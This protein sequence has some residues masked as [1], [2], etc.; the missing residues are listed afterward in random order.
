MKRAAWSAMAI[1]CLAVAAY[2]LFVY[3]V[4][5]FAANV[6]HPG[7]RAHF[8][9]MALPLRVHIFASVFALALGSLQFAP[10][11][12]KAWPRL[13][14]VAGRLYLGVGVGLGGL[15][16]LYMALNA[17]GGPLARAGFALLALAWL[18]TGL[19]AYRAIRRGQVAE[20]RQWMVRNW[21]LT[22]AA[23][24]LR[25]YLPAAVAAGI[26]FT[27][28]FAAIAWLCWVPNLALAQYLLARERAPRVQAAPVR[29]ATG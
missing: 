6:R 3:G 12:R 21:S 10:R 28:A 15:S 16:G 23:V 26:D 8:I 2:A 25:F 19:E 24:T 20:H 17:F 9:E 4:L 27:T 11:L 13:H 22:L 5:P 1:L 7:V 18:Y 14:R 29:A